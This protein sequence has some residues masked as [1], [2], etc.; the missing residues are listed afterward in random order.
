MRFYF[1]GEKTMTTATQSN[2]STEEKIELSRILRNTKKMENNLTKH[3]LDLNKNKMDH[4]IDKDGNA[5]TFIS[6]KT[7]FQVLNKVLAA[8]TKSVTESDK[9][10]PEQDSSITRAKRI[11]S[12]KKENIR[13]LTTMFNNGGHMVRYFKYVTRSGDISAEV[14]TPKRIRDFIERLRVAYK[15]AEVI[16]KDGKRFLK[17]SLE[18]RETMLKLNIY[19]S[20][21]H[22]CE[23]FQD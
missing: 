19:D 7:Q 9:Y 15:D 2:L 14:V 21:E 16:E 18:F 17:P 5:T 13:I 12:R 22:M 6:S 23:D 10:D 11:Y 1:T 8:T 3:N 20:V 4:C